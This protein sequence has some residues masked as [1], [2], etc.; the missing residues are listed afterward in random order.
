MIRILFFRIF[1]SLKLISNQALEYFYDLY[2]N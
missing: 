1:Y 2:E